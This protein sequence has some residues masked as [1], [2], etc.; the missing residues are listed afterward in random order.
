[1][2]LK[3]MIAIF[4]ATLLVFL[5]ACNLPGSP[6]IGGTNPDPAA[7]TAAI[8]TEVANIVASTAVAQTQVAVIVA[9]TAAAQTAFANA[10]ASTLTAMATNTPEFTHTPSL[11]STP[12]FTL[13]PTFT[14]TPT[15]TLTSSVPRV[16]V[17]VETNC[18][19]G[20]GTVYGIL[21]VLRVGETAEIVGRD[22]GEGNWIIRLPSNPAII[23]WVWRNYATT[24][25]DTGPLPVF[26]PPPTPTP[27]ASFQVSYID[28]ETCGA[29][30]GLEFKITNNGSVTWESNRIIATDLTTSVSK[31]ND[32]NDFPNYTGCALTSADMNLEAGEVGTTTTASFPANPAGHSFTATIRV[33]SLDG[34]AG[35]CLEK[36]ITFTP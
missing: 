2:F 35:V 16:S 20:P 15:F 30:Y 24:T 17:S 5:S 3:K 21:G 27:A 9:S 29:A 1:M 14:F 8:Q 13:T 26:T 10:V 12:T 33:C 23:C 22:L 34:M 28:F 6:V 31:S 25:G 32:R 11:T 4:V 7:A 19:S 18:R 36:T